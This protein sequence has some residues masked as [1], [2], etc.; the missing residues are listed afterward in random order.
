[1]AYYNDPTENPEY[2]RNQW[3]A[4]A[5]VAVVYAALLIFFIAAGLTH[6]VPPPPEYGI[7]LDMSGGGGGGAAAEASTPEPE[8]VAS[9]PATRASSPRISTQR[10]EATP[11]VVAEQPKNT[12]ATEQTTTQPE[13]NQM[14]L[15]SK[16]AGLKSG[17]GEGG[18]SGSGTGSGNGPG[19]GSGS[20]GG[21]GS[22][23]GAGTGAFFLDG[24]PVVYKAF[25]NGGENL[26]GMVFVEFRADKDG[27]VVYAKAGVRG[28]TLNDAALWKE[29][30]RAAM[31]SKFKKKEDAAA[32]EKGTIRYKFVT[33]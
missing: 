6:Q 14:A 19:S 8:A 11:K 4:G 27:N 21:Q 15:F 10:A 17:G 28:T 23:A 24:R 5:C 7:E 25:P 32:E 33:R 2:K 30:E 3:I 16:K 18:G 31:K 1:M 29:C 20:G 13:V 22:G 9:Q 12:S 26:N